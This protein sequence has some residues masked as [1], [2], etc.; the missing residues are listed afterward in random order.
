MLYFVRMLARWLSNISCASMKTPPTIPIMF[1]RVQNTEAGT[2]DSVIFPIIGKRFAPIC[3]VQIT[4]KQSCVNII[5]EFIQKFI[6]QTAA[7]L[8]LNACRV[9]AVLV[10]KKEKDNH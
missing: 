4:M 3:I 8:Y 5:P 10:K 2:G 9:I 1:N 6:A 7:F